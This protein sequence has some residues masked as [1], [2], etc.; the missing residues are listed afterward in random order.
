MRS[1]D[2][3]RAFVDDLRLVCVQWIRAFGVAETSEIASMLM[4]L[5]WVTGAS[6]P[7]I[8][9]TLKSIRAAAAELRSKERATPQ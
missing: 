2:E 3:V 5:D 9:E 8:T 6:G 1:E 4:V 7:Q